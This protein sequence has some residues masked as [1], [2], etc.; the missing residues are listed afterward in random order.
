MS[1]SLISRIEDLTQIL[2]ILSD[3][4]WTQTRDEIQVSD[5]LL[6]S[7]NLKLILWYQSTLR[8]T[9]MTKLDHSLYKDTHTGH[10]ISSQPHAF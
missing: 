5:L 1:N 8:V 6:K 10:M 4:E 3:T 2:I 9:D 7:S